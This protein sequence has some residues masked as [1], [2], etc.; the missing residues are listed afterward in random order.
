MAFMQMGVPP[1]LIMV[2]G[3]FCG[4]WCFDQFRQPFEAAGYRVS[5]P[6]LPGHAGKGA[7]SA[8][9]GQS[10]RDYTRFVA[11]RVRESPEPPVLLGHSMGGSSANSRPRGFPSGRSC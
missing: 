8:V 6:N 10:M 11:E 7:A 2:H 4:G 3:A 9:A 1:P 5:T